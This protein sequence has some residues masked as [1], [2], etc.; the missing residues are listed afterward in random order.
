M[1]SPN[2]RDG[3]P[4]VHFLSPNEDVSSER[5][6]Q[7]MHILAKEAHANSHTAPAIAIWLSST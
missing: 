7:L 3:A 2:G 6:L 5:R 4:F 1:E